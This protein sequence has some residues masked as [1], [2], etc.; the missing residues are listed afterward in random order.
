MIR[1]FRPAGFTLVELLVVIAII[2]I[3]ASLLLPA[4]RTARGKASTVAC[5]NNLR[6][7]GL[8]VLLYC[9]TYNDWIP[10]G[11]SDQGSKTSPRFWINRASPF[12][13][14][15]N[16]AIPET[17]KAYPI[18]MCPVVQNDEAFWAPAL[19]YCMQ[20]HIC[21]GAYQS[22]LS[23]FND[24]STVICMVDGTGASD[25]S[26]NYATD[27]LWPDWCRVAVRHG[28]FCNVLYLDGHVAAKSGGVYQKDM[29][30]W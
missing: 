7:L 30:P 29:E 10:E 23:K 13:G 26:R 24:T 18:F 25:F 17:S 12:V 9:D 6:Q 11:D 4:L 19:S 14:I 28:M 16:T 22:R 3:L 5:V 27:G 2:A 8:G 1:R 20:Y 21:N 15:D